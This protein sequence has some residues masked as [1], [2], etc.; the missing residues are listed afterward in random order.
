MVERQDGSRRAG[1][2]T[3]SIQ[4]MYLTFQ[5]ADETYAVNIAGVTEIVG[6]QHVS[7]IP[8]VPAYIK[9]AMN[10]R[11]KVIPVMDQRLRFGL[12]ERAYD[13][14][15]T[16][17]VL[18]L[19]GDADGAGRGP[20]DRRRDDSQGQDRSARR[21]GWAKGINRGLIQGM[22]KL[23]DRVSIILNIPRLVYDPAATEAGTGPLTAAA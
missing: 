16:I 2:R 7:E 21:I 6:V 12:P 23:N 13:E 20:R 9:G 11:G 22:G 15:T 4:D 10:L 1:L 17:I 3:V 19:E 8:D 5:V 14:R 18:D